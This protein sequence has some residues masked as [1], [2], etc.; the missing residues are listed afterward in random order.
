MLY[1][2]AMRVLE[3]RGVERPYSYLRRNGFTHSMARSIF[4]GRVL[5]IRV[6]QIEQ[7]C[8][9]LNCVPSDL[10]EWRDGGDGKQIAE[11]H[12]I[13]ALTRGNS[14]T[15]ISRMVKDIPVEKLDRLG[16]MIEE[17]RDA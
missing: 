8:L 10:F 16:A 3:L 15:H 2:N 7:L 4:G 5:Q 17:L 14:A 12:A 13:H 9:L 6:E 1:F 11:N